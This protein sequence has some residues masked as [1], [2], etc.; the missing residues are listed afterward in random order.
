MKDIKPKKV[1]SH[2]IKTKK[3]IK[4]LKVAWYLNYLLVDIKSWNMARGPKKHLKRIAAP[5]S[6]M[7]DKLGGIYTTR[8]SQGPHKLR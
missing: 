3:G 1:R 4:T 5:K 2:Q 6:W 8:P 7:L